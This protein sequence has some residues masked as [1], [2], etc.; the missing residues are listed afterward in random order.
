MQ[1]HHGKRL[2]I[3]ASGFSQSATVKRR[4][5]NAMFHALT[6]RGD[7]IRRRHIINDLGRVW[8]H[9]EPG[10]LAGRPGVPSDR[11]GRTRGRH[12]V[13]VAGRKLQLR[14]GHGL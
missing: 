8:F 9:T 10:D 4:A 11:S 14:L 13:L 1:K 2:L 6:P 5:R 12:H 3:R 7:Y